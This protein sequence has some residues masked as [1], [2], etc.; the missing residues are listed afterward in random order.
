M[1]A[2]Q[3]YR[4]AEFDKGENGEVVVIAGGG[5]VIALPEDD[6]D[7]FAAMIAAKMKI[8]VIALDVKSNPDEYAAA[9]DM[10]LRR[11]SSMGL[12]CVVL[13]AGD[14]LIELQPVGA[15]GTVE[16]LRRRLRVLQRMTHKGT[17]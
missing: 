14:A 8:G 5:V 11:F 1:K 2:F 17:A 15:D 6:A 12:P 10:A 4:A 3:N 7:E 9:L 13:D 16:P